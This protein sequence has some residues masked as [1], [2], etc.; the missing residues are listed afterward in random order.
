[1]TYYYRFEE[2]GRHD[3]GGGDTNHPR[4]FEDIPDED[5]GTIQD[6]LK[7]DN[8]ELGMLEA[9]REKNDAKRIEEV[10]K[11]FLG[12]IQD[13]KEP[14]QEELDRSM[15]AAIERDIQ[16]ERR[17]AKAQFN[18]VEVFKRYYEIEQS[19]KG[20]VLATLSAAISPL[21]GMKSFAITGIDTLRVEMLFGRWKEKRD[22]LIIALKKEKK[23]LSDAQ[24]IVGG[25]RLA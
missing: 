5:V 1:M 15:K 12:M 16:R 3:I 6:I 8:V 13:I 22:S 21:L 23:R 4:E 2:Q 11:H 24:Y 17:I 20:A 10:S 19:T 9:W 25:E 7:S 14:T 18:V